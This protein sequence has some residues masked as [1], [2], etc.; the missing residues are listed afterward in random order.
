MTV[1]RARLI[2]AVA[3]I[4]TFLA[5]IAAGLAFKPMPP[6]P[7]REGSWLERELKLSPEQR[8]KMRAIWTDVM[9]DAGRQSS[10][11]RR[12]ELQKERDEAVRLLIP[13]EHLSEYDL[14]LMEYARKAAELGKERERAFQ[15]AVDRTTKILDEAQKKRYLELMK[16]RPERGPH[17]PGGPV[18]EPGRPGER[19]PP[20]SGT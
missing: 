10:M 13:E 15:E 11:D 12:R 3:F 19:P 7:P 6:P 17:R 20:G 18:R 9:R 4:V 2:I 5:G 16:T 1:T 8:E 14:T